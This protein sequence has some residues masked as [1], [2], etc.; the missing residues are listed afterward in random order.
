MRR[1]FAQIALNGNKPTTAAPVNDDQ[2]FRQRRRR[3][4]LPGWKEIR[5][6]EHAFALSIGDRLGC[7]IY[8][9][10]KLPTPNPTPEAKAKVAEAAAKTAWNTKVEAYHLCP[11]QDQ[12]AA[13]YRASATPGCTDPGPSIRR[14]SRSRSSPRARSPAAAATAPPAAAMM[15]PTPKQ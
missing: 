15:N 2:P 3:C 11:P 6:E 12:V 13:R 1:G 7:R 14:P 8:R 10:A 9:V 4:A 5:N